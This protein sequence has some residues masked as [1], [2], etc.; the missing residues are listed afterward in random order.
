MQPDEQHQMQRVSFTGAR[1]ENTDR[2]SNSPATFLMMPLFSGLLCA[3][4]CGHVPVAAAATV[5]STLPLIHPLSLDKNYTAT[6]VS[7]CLSS[8]VG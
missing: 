3:H 7:S 1:H 5:L 2:R 4:C 8:G 6:S